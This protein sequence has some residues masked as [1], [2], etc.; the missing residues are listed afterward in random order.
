LAGS[1]PPNDGKSDSGIEQ[2]PSVRPASTNA[3]AAAAARA[4]RGPPFRPTDHRTSLRIWRPSDAAPASFRPPCHRARIEPAT[5]LRPDNYCKINKAAIWVGNVTAPGFF[6]ALQHIE[7][8]RINRTVP[9]SAEAVQNRGGNP[10]T[11]L[12]VAQ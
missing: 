6:V 7:I 8:Y 10:E 3:S 9:S 2:P 12:R 1:L 5:I 4:D 11:D